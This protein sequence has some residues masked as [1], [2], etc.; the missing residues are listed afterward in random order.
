M[1]DVSSAIPC[2]VG[3]AASLALDEEQLQ[4]NGRSAG[5]ALGD[6]KGSWDVKVRG[7]LRL[8]SGNNIRDIR[9]PGRFCL[10]VCCCNTGEG[11]PAKL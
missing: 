1:A 6:S 7:L 11:F 9:W 3:A 8:S 5:V 10:I 4:K 2:T